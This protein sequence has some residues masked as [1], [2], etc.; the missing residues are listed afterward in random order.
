LFHHDDSWHRAADASIGLEKV[1]ALFGTRW[2]EHIFT[3]DLQNYMGA[4][5]G[6]TDVDSLRASPVASPK[7][8]WG[9]PDK[10]TFPVASPKDPFCPA[11]PDT[12][13]GAPS[14]SPPHRGRSGHAGHNE[15]RGGEWR[16]RSLSGTLNFNLTVAYLAKEVM[17]A[18][19]H[20]D[21]FTLMA[22]EGQ[23]RRLVGAAQ[24][25]RVAGVRMPPRVPA[26]SFRL[27]SPL[28]ALSSRRRRL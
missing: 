5:M 27:F 1:P 24:P 21:I 3:A 22:A 23:A 26:L 11:R 20:D 17:R 6:C 15:K 18:V 8:I 2:C 12:V 28:P 25:P 10:K 13:S 16:G 4:S 7:G 14:P 9:A 19:T